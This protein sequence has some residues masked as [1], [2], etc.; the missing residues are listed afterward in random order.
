MNEEE[1]KTLDNA[2][3]VGKGDTEKVSINGF[4]SFCFSQ[5]EID[6]ILYEELR[7]Y[8]KK[9]QKRFIN[10][11]YNGNTSNFMKRIEKKCK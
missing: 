11:Y 6:D 4:L 7:S 10:D 3:F 8:P 1:L 2:Y 5:S 9:V